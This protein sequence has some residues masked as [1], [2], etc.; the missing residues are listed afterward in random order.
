MRGHFVFSPFWLRLHASFVDTAKQPTSFQKNSRLILATHLNHLIL[1]DVFKI[2][3]A[4]YFIFRRACAPL[5]AWIPLDLA[6]LTGFGNV[7][8]S[9]IDSELVQI[10][11][12][13]QK[14]TNIYGLRPTCI[15]VPGGGEGAHPL[16]ALIHAVGHP[17]LSRRSSG[18]LSFLMLSFVVS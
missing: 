1:V 9:K 7:S 4:V 17:P 12:S 10:F 15:L 11:T 13:P 14:N 16:L 3:D 5:R 8:E 2:R 18:V 6:A